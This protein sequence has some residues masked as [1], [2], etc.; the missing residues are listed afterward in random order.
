MNAIFFLGVCPFVFSTGVV[1]FAAGSVSPVKLL[2]SM[3]KSIA[4]KQRSM[5]R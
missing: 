2:S 4:Y 3:A 5:L 1:I